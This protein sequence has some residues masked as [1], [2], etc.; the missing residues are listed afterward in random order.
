[1]PR[2]WFDDR[3]EVFPPCSLF[4]HPACNLPVSEK[5][6]HFASIP[7]GGKA[8]GS[9]RPAVNGSGTLGFALAWSRFDRKSPPE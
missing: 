1:V 8:G 2:R 9:M 4:S 6:R 3:C 5:T 7:G